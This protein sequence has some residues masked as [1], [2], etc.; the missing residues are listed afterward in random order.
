MLKPVHLVGSIPL[1]N[2]ESVMTTCCSVLRDRISRVPDGETGVRSNWIHWQKDLLGAH[3]AIHVVG[4]G[5]NAD[6]VMPKFAVKGDHKGQITFEELGYAAA[7]LESYEKYSALRAQGKIDQQRF[8]VSLPTPLAAIACYVETS[9]QEQLFSPYMKRLFAE[10]QT[11]INT[12]PGEQLAIQWDVAIEF[13]VLEGLFPVWF[14]EPFETIAT[15]LAGLAELIPNA[16]EVGFHF[17]YG[18]AGNKHFKEPEDMTLLVNLANRATELCGR[19]IQWIHMPV[20]IDRIDD[21][22]FKPLQNLKFGNL[23]QL[24]LGLIHEQDGVEGAKK[25]MTAADR[26]CADYGIATE[27]GL[28]RRDPDVAL[29]LLNLQASV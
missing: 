25:R 14:E 29:Q 6:R 17:C 16:V 12:I 7:A 11:I 26:F 28:G 27:C 13:A 4:E 19:S 5:R 24:F 18:D 1:D 15:Q 3:P 20:P 22:Y 2:A 10:V 8:Q 23:H 21:D 9:S